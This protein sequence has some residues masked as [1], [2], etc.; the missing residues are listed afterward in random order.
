L[1]LWVMNRLSALSR[2][3]TQR[4]ADPSQARHVGLAEH[5]AVTGLWSS[6][7]AVVLSNLTSPSLAEALQTEM[8][9]SSNRNS[10][11]LLKQPRSAR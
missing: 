2:C 5:P 11:I 7:K 8:F 9:C 10:G 3:P 6:L 1:D 4:P